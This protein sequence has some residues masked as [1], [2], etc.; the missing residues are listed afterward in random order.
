MKFAL[1]SY[2]ANF[3][4]RRK[5]TGKQKKGIIIHRIP[6]PSRWNFIQLADLVADQIPNLAIKFGCVRIGSLYPFGGNR[7]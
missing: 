4:G 5:L 7:S 3:K 1:S 2:L 6:R